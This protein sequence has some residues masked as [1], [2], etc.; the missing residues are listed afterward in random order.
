[1]SVSLSVIKLVEIAVLVKS[2][3]W[4]EHLHLNFAEYFAESP[5]SQITH[6][7]PL[8]I[9]PPALRIYRL[10]S[11]LI[12]LWM[13]KWGPLLSHKRG[14]IFFSTTHL[15]WANCGIYASMSN[16]PCKGAQSDWWRANNFKF[17][18]QILKWMYVWLTGPSFHLKYSI[19]VECV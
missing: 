6:A 4:S 9:S 12:L 3:R 11:L 10:K 19:I 1:M 2:E 7:I 15:I 18:P 14:L 13:D 17:L 5:F 8:S 16:T